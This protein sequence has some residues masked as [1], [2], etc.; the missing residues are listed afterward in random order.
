MPA[1]SKEEVNN[2]INY[3]LHFGHPSD[4]VLRA[5]LTLLA[6]ILHEPCFDILRTQE[7]LGYIVGANYMQGTSYMSLKIVI[8]SAHSPDHLEKRIDAFL[9]SF[10][11]ILQEMDVEKPKNAMIAQYLEDYKSQGE[12]TQFY[13]GQILGQYNFFH[14]ERTAALLKA[15]TKRDII[16]TFMTYVHP[17]GSKRSKLS[18]Q[19]Y[20]QQVDTKPITEM[21]EKHGIK[22]EIK[23]KLTVEDLQ[24]SVEQVGKDLPFSAGLE[25]MRKLESL[26][27]LDGISASELKKLLPLGEPRKPVAE[28]YDGITTKL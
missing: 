18:I 5:R 22:H 15:I 21:L 17:K 25:V 13:W 16:D 8:Q 23:A 2:G 4:D 6:T 27:V 24:K 9:E 19:L 1:S 12:E 11:Q 10:V 14:A 3:I 28:Y 26:D 20:S 7:Q